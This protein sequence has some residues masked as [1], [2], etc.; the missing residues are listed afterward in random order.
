MTYSVIYDGNCN[1]CTTLVQW[2]EI[3]DRGQQ[4]SYIPM[5]DTGG[6]EQF[7]ITEQD[8][9]QGMILIDES[10][11]ERRWQGSRA[12]EKIGTLLPLGAAFVTLY[13]ALPGLQ[14]SGDSFYAFIRD[15][16]YRLFGRRSQTYQSRYPKCDRCTES[17]GRSSTQSG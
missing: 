1:L 15:N 3:W 16:R 4:F 14:Q 13:L 17:F 7:Q 12:A 8:C 2:L 11:P 10:S 6:L 9:E 5:Q